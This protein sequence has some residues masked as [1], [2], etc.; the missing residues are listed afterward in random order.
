VEKMLGRV[1]GSDTELGGIFVAQAHARILA[2]LL[3]KFLVS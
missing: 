3:V 1:L 2:R